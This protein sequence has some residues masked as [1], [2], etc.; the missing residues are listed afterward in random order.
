MAYTG[1]LMLVRVTDGA[2]DW[3]D[4]AG[5]ESRSLAYSVDRA[6]FTQFDPANPQATPGKYS[7]PEA[8]QLKVSGSFTAHDEASVKRVVASA[9]SPANSDLFQIIVPGIGTFEGVFSITFDFSGDAA[10]S[11]SIELLSEGVPAF[12]AAA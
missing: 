4:F 6:N 5:M 11:G 3:L 8:Q 12:T 9:L 2:A 10:V 1:R 7:L